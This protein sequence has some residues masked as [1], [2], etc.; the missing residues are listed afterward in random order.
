MS[1]V[2]DNWAAAGWFLQF[3]T[4]AVLSC[5]L[6]FPRLVRRIFVS[7]GVLIAVDGVA[8]LLFAVIIRV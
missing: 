4:A 7:L 2:A 1:E 5:G 3:A 8:L 6:T